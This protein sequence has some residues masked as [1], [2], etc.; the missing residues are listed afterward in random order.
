MFILVLVPLVRGLKMLATNIV[1]EEIISNASNLTISTLK[2]LVPRIKWITIVAR[3]APKIK[4]INDNF[5]F[6]KTVNTPN[7]IPIRIIIG[8]V[9][10]AINPP[11]KLP[12][13]PT[14]ATKPT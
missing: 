5:D 8:S 9:P 14:L 3:T 1:I 11:A 4:Y 7:K 13:K 12:T 2:S 6:W 10:I